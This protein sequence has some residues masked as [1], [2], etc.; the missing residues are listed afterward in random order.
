MADITHGS[1]E[2]AADAASAARQEIGFVR[3]LGRAGA[4]HFYPAAA[5][6]QAGRLSS[7]ADET[8]AQGSSLPQDWASGA[9]PHDPLYAEQTKRLLDLASRTLEYMR[10]GLSQ[11]NC[12]AVCE[13]LLPETR[14]MSVAMTDDRYV[15]GFAGRY[16]DDFPLGSPIHTDATHEVL[17][18]KIAQV[19]VQSR[20]VG[21]YG[22]R[23][24]PAGV[25]AP[26]VVRDRAVG[27]IK[28]YF[29]SPASVDETQQAIATGFAG[30]L[31]TQLSIAELDRQ[32][33]L[34]TKAELQALQA[35]INPHFLFNT[36]NT[37][38]SLV[39][40]DPM[41]ARDLLREF[42]KFYRSTLDDSEDLITLE[43]ELEQTERYLQFEIARFGENRITVS[44]SMQEGLE[45]LRVPSFVL[46]PVVENSVNHAMRPGEALHITIDIRSEGDDVVASVADDGVGMAEQKLSRLLVER[47][48]SKAGAGIALHNVDAR[49]RAAFGPES[50]ITATSQI[51][52][53]TTLELRMHGAALR[54]E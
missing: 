24:I 8:G 33:E 52:K 46:Q 30:L 53:G 50:G 31:S 27:T 4:E 39:R 48:P 44:T 3:Q 17:T 28:L 32:V 5:Q 11:E 14:A 43:R 22:L 34:A 49:L 41:R 12:Q 15:L 51:G 38:A 19:F 7:S 42:A 20:S 26:L 25:V 9:R 23:T 36:I 37:I 1:S 2:S 16:V 29:E 35:Q 6:T 10:G 47:N 13:L 45:H 54:L 21:T 40:T 18:S